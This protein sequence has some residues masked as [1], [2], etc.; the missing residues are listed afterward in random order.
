MNG[1][2]DSKK[3]DC[4]RRSRCGEKEYICVYLWKLRRF[5]Y[6]AIFSGPSYLVYTYNSI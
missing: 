1:G 2:T 5:I 6:W 4:R 3:K